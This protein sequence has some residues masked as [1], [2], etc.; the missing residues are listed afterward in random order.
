MPSAKGKL[1]AG[2]HRIELLCF[3]REVLEHAGGG[4][5]S[6]WRLFCRYRLNFLL[7]DA[8]SCMTTGLQCNPLELLCT[9]RPRFALATSIE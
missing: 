6:E 7:M 2:P 4:C 5:S 1:F 9:V 8:S 3:V